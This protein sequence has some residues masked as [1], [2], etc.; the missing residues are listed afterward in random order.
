[1]M[2]ETLNSRSRFVRYSLF[3][4]VGTDGHPQALRAQPPEDA[5]NR[6]L[7]GLTTP[8]R[9]GRITWNTRTGEICSCRSVTLSGLLRFSHSGY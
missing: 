2:Y 8:E 4:P 7:I 6:R 5:Q 3:E 1:V 9:V